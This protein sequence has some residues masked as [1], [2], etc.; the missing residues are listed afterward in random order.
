MTDDL[1]K[2]RNGRM[3]KKS[4]GLNARQDSEAESRLRAMEAEFKADAVAEQVE[5]ARRAKVAAQW[6][7][8]H[9]PDLTFDAVPTFLRIAE[10][11]R[12]SL[13]EFEDYGRR[14]N[15]IL[16]SETDLGQIWWCDPE[17]REISSSFFAF[18]LGAATSVRFEIEFRKTEP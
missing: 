12:G 11:D 13:A 8:E 14:G 3:V 18:T 10:P 6:L 1:I 7:S 17:A 4:C 16:L 2:A 15:A 9:R 5:C